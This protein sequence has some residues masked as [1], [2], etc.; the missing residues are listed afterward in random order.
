MEAPFARWLLEL[1]IIVFVAVVVSFVAGLEFA[2][3]QCSKN[4]IAH[5]I[6]MKQEA[7]AKAIEDSKARNEV[8]YST[9][10]DRVNLEGKIIINYKISPKAG[11]I[12]LNADKSSEISERCK[13][14]LEKNKLPTYH[15][16]DHKFSGSDWLKQYEK[17]N[18]SSFDYDEDWN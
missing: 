6:L 1:I 14:P 8:T 10:Y 16:R 17:P 18:S 2:G 9:S 3:Y 15:W 4:I 7:E 11:N 12:T 13:K 5:D